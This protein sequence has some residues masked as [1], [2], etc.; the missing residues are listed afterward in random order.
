MSLVLPIAI[1]PEADRA[2]WERL[3][4]RGGLLDDNGA[5][6]HLRGTSLAT[7]EHRYG[8]WLGSLVRVEPESLLQ[9]PADRGTVSRLMAW[10]EALGHLAPM[11]KLMFVSGTLRVLSA[12]APKTDWGPQR[13]LEAFLKQSAG[14]GNPERK[15]GRVLSSDVLLNAGIKLATL[16]ADAATTELVAAKRRRD[17]TMVAMLALM[18]MRRRAFAGLRLSHSIHFTEQEIVVALPEEMTKTGL[19]W[20]APV[21]AQVAALLRRYLSETRPWF[22]ARGGQRHDYLWVGDRGAPFFDLN[23]FGNRIAAITTRITGVRV[24]PHFFRDAAATTLARISPESARL[25]RPILAHSSLG[26]AGAITFRQAVSRPVGT[27]PL[28]SNV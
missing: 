6:S 24:S 12:A 15:R 13:R 20:E 4:R 28:K 17:G 19:A 26:T 3:L 8:R 21:P 25:I 11:S 16:Q 22:M 9:L 10:L 2:M 7:L 5:L 18:P 27:T 14:R 1:W 23:Y